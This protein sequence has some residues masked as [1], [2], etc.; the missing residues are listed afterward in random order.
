VVANEVINEIKKKKK[1]CVIVK[2]E[3]EKAYY[4]VSWNYLMYMMERLGFC[5]KWI[6]W[7]KGCLSYASVSILVNGSPT[8]EFNPQRGLRQGDPLAP[9]LFLIAAEGLV[10][11]VRQANNLGFLEGV[12]VGSRETKICMLQFADDIMFVPRAI[13]QNIITLKSILKCF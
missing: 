4:T 13:T 5:R 2:V 11:V 1:E 6:H 12:K 8:T 7:I 10:R 3:F 9:F